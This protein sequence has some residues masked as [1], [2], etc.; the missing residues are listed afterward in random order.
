MARK[1]GSILSIK[2]GMIFFQADT[3]SRKPNKKLKLKLRHTAGI[4]SFA[5]QQAKRDYS[6]TD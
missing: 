6:R 5:K 3:K 1:R 4:W 2:N